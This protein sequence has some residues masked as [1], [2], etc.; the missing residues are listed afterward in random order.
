[1]T[2]DGDGVSGSPAGAHGPLR[3]GEI[4]RI[5]GPDASRMEE[6]GMNWKTVVL[7]GI[8]FWLA[9]FVVSFATYGTLPASAGRRWID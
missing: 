5:S 9:T 8:A 2:Q 6:A 1:M 4:S 3:R 7:G